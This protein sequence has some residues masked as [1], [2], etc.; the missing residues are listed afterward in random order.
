MPLPAVQAVPFQ[1]LLD[2][3][4]LPFQMATAAGISI[5][6]GGDITSISG[7]PIGRFGAI[8]Q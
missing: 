4:A 3:L 5:T 6:W 1:A 2:G 8:L 7:K